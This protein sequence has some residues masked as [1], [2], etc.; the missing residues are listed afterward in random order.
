MRACLTLVI[1]ARACDQHGPAVIEVRRWGLADIEVL[2]P[3]LRAQKPYDPFENWAHHFFLLY[4]LFFSD[5][6]MSQWPAGIF[7]ANIMSADSSL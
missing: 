2:K 5:L 1:S 7:V 6:G 4:W 3:G